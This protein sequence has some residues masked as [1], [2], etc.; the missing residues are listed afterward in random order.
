MG[1]VVLNAISRVSLGSKFGHETIRKVTSV[2][3]CAHLRGGGGVNNWISLL[4]LAM[5][6][7]QGLP[8]IWST[9]RLRF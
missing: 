5:N 4:V 7:S 1:V 8:G 2:L 9:V 3:P 6:T